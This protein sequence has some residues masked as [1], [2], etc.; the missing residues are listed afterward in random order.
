MHSSAHQLLRD[1]FGFDDFRLG[2]SEVI[3]LLLAGQPVLAVMPT[4]AGKSLCYQIPA[5]VSKQRS[6]IISPLTALMDDQVIA[7]EGV[8]VSAAR[9]HSGRERHENVAAWR[10]FQSGTCQLLYLSPERLMTD[11]MLASLKTIDIGMFVVDEAHCISK[12]GVS[13][14]PEYEHLGQLQHHFPKAVIAGFTA[15]ADAATRRDIATKLTSGRAKIMVQG[16]DRPNLHLAVQPKLNWKSQLLDFV[17]QHDGQNGIVYCLSRKQTEE[18]ETFLRGHDLNA[19]AYHAGMDAGERRERQNR[20]MSEDG[21]IMAA[22]IAFGM[23]IDKPDIR[24]VMHA[25]LPGSMEAYYQE[26]GRAGRD[27]LAAD[28]LLLYG[29]DDMRMR[30]QFIENDGADGDHKFREQKRLDALIGYCEASG[31]RRQSLLRYFDEDAGPCGNCDNCLNPPQMLDGTREAQM[32]LSAIARTGGMFGQAHVID[33]VR[34]TSTPKTRQRGHDQLKTFG[35]GAAHARPWWQ[36]FV[37]QMLAAGHINL[38]VEKHGR[39]EITQGGDAILRGGGIFEYRHIDVGKKAGKTKLRSA[40]AEAGLSVDDAAL[41]SRLKA[42]RLEL[43]KARQAP[44]FTILADAV[45]LQLATKRPQTRAEF[46]ALNGVGPAKLKKWAEVFLAVV[47][48]RGEESADLDDLAL[49]NY[50]EDV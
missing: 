40:E 37:R 27:G 15:T 12:W 29:L 6:I 45:L 22:T 9:I 47:N 33:V 26:I 14:R 4:G 1:V 11:A 19:L 5:L 30:R 28:T 21:L 23:G 31:C 49:E 38:D 24:F 48:A 34:G 43:A 41:L 32:V 10:A 16:F 36:V 13:F 2:Q 3:E 46:A 39:L 20:F 35:V 18:A 50:D 17:R 25:S 8:N 7:L 44:A 42:R